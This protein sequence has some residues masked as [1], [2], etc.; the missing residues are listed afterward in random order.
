MVRV[1]NVPANVV[2]AADVY[3]CDFACGGGGEE[4]GGELLGGNALDGGKGCVGHFAG[5]VRGK[6]RSGGCAKGSSM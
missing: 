1:S 2:G 6:G 3:D 4:E 5:I